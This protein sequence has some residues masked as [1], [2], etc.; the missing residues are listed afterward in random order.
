MPAER[1]GVCGCWRC[2]GMYLGS[3]IYI[4]PGGGG[5]GG[6][7]NIGHE[8]EETCRYTIIVRGLDPPALHRYH[9]YRA[10]FCCCNI[11]IA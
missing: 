4:M 10:N 3:C 7:G 11:M 9:Y 2:S 8:P 5:R 6:G 1:E